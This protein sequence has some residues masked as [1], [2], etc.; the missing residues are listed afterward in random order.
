MPDTNTAPDP[1]RATAAAA[2][3]ARVA[4]C[5]RVYHVTTGAIL[6]AFL[7]IIA[8]TTLSTGPAVQFVGKALY[9]VILL[10]AVASLA[11]WLVRVRLEKVA[12][13]NS[14]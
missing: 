14:Q 1:A 7:L 4:L 8:L 5:Q 2:A 12:A 10:G 6:T 3:A 11:T 9:F 13:A